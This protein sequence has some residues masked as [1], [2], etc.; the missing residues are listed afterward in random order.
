MIEQRT[1]CGERFSEVN[2]SSESL[3]ALLIISSVLIVLFLALPKLEEI[4]PKQKF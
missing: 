1:A 2:Y 3:E 4:F